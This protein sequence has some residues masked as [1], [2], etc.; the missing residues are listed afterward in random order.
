MP[1]GSVIVVTD[2][3]AFEGTKQAVDEFLIKYAPKFKTVEVNDT[4]IAIQTQKVQTLTSKV[5]R[6]RSEF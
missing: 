5:I 3:Q 4:F 1:V 6:S 2:Y